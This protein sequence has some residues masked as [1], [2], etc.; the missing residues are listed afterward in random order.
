[1]LPLLGVVSSAFGAHRKDCL[2]LEIIL[3]Q[4]HEEVVTSRPA[5]AIAL[6]AADQ[7]LAAVIDFNQWALALARIAEV[8]ISQRSRDD[9]DPLLVATGSPLS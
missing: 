9:C 5:P 6:N 8:S 2:G 3:R 7:P 1:M 4:R